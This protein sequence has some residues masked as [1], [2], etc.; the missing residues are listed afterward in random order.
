MHIR[1]DKQKIKYTLH[2]GINLSKF[3][4]KSDDTAAQCEI[5]RWERFWQKPSLLWLNSYIGD[6]MFLFKKM[7]F[8]DDGQTSVSDVKTTKK[9]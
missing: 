4:Q 7:F 9:I 5:K 8:L 1:L 2:I 6:V 3:S